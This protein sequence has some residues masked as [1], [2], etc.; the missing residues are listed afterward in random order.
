MVDICVCDLFP[1]VDGGCPFGSPASTESDFDLPF[2]V[3]ALVRFVGD[4]TPES[5]S[6]P[7]GESIC[8]GVVEIAE[9]VAEVEVVVFALC[10]AIS[11]FARFL[12]TITRFC[13]STLSA[14]VAV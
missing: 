4:L 13:N 3:D 6:S 10:S 2:L 7:G 11:A 14:S 8:D 5:I 12:F 9:G 1:F